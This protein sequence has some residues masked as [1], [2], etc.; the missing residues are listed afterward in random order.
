MFSTRVRTALVGLT[1]AG[2]LAVGAHTAEA[3]SVSRIGAS[4]SHGTAASLIYLSSGSKVTL[5]FGSDDPRSLGTWHVA[6]TDNG[7]TLLDRT[8][9][10]AVPAW[11]ISTQRTL[12]KGV[13][14]I[15][16]S[17]QNLSNGE[18]CTYA[19]VNKV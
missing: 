6:I 17:A 14:S 4:C 19:L 13:H 12:A 7:T 11:T 2:V 10:P 9:T 5:G 3:K 16:L 1:A 18:V 8:L 15:A